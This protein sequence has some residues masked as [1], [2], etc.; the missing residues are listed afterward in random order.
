MTAVVAVVVVVVV[1]VVVAVVV[2][3]GACV[4]VVVATTVATVVVVGASSAVAEVANVCDTVE[5]GVDVAEVFAA[6]VV[7]V[8]AVSNVDRM[9]CSVAVTFSVV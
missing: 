3:G 6:V 9:V 2:M 1:V 4:A 5:E 7:C 8:P